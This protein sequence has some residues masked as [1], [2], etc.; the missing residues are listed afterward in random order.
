MPSPPPIDYDQPDDTIVNNIIEKL[1]DK[2]IFPREKQSVECYDQTEE[3][4]KSRGK[5]YALFSS[6]IKKNND[7]LAKMKA[8]QQVVKENRERKEAL[9]LAKKKEESM[10]RQL[11]AEAK[12]K[13]EQTLKEKEL[14][15]KREEEYIKA[16]MI[17]IKQAMEKQ[18]KTADK[19]FEERKLHENVKDLVNE[20]PN[21][22]MQRSSLE[23]H[24]GMVLEKERLQ[25][26]QQIQM[27]L[28]KRDAENLKLLNKCFHCWYSFVRDNRINVARFRA[29]TDWRCLVRSW[30]KW[31]CRTNNKLVEKETRCHSENLRRLHI[32]ELRADNHYKLTLLRVC[33]Q[34]WIHFCL[35]SKEEKYAE[36]E[37]Q[38][39]KMK[40]DSFLAAAAAAKTVA[41]TEEKVETITIVE[42][43]NSTAVDQFFNA[44]SSSNMKLNLNDLSSDA[45]DIQYSQKF[46]TRPYSAKPGTTKMGPPQEDVFSGSEDERPRPRVHIPGR[47]VVYNSHRKMIKQQKDKIREQELIIKEL[48]FAN[49]HKEIMQQVANYEVLLGKLSNLATNI[50]PENISPVKS[51][52]SHEHSEHSEFQML[53][54]NKMD[55][56]GCKGPVNMASENTGSQTTGDK[57]ESE[58]KEPLC[59]NSI[60]NIAQTTPAS[61][62]S[63][64]STDRLSFRNALPTKDSKFLKSKCCL[65]QHYFSKFNFVAMEERADV[66]RKLKEERERRKVEKEK[67]KAEEMKLREEE[68]RQKEEEEKRINY[69]QLKKKRVL[70]KAKEEQR[71]ILIKHE[72]ELLE[73]ADAENKRRIIRFS[74]WLPWRKLV[75]TRQNLNALANEHYR[76]VIIKKIF[77]SWSSFVRLVNEKQLQIAST[78][79]NELLLKRSFS[80]WLLVR[81]L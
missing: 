10:R 8:R 26:N 30:N 74:G 41:V 55:S 62:P 69:E 38:Q 16:E 29:I 12:M 2:P 66:R 27:R 32:L 14:K 23:I 31:R 45:E 77:I 11:I 37:K 43:M 4:S 78:F 25:K 44:N 28:A 24:V 71:L 35:V 65:L 79:F 53:T 17:K 52:S 73:K 39:R 67:Q 33:F 76:K 21:E 20:K 61:Q 72:Q 60:V 1:L 50:P 19:L 56:N 63:N 51:L 48:S 40:M 13:T 49:H 47:A 46:K 34:S 5:G 81:P 57:I 7:F 36:I 3:S 70:E 59:T 64:P 22:P 75:S 15:E 80:H 6:P 9:T 68:Q 58:T 18:K 42:P 54:D